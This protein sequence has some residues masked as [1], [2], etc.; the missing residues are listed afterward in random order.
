MA[1]TD[2]LVISIR[3]DL[4]QLNRQLQQ[5]DQRLNNTQQQGQQTGQSLDD[6]FSSASDS[7]KQLAA[8]IGIAT[9]AIVGMSAATSN[10]V[11]EF[12][13][14]ANSLGLSYRQLERLNAVAAA[15]NLETDMM[16]D[17][18]KTLNEQVGEAVNGNKDYEDSFKRLGLSM[19]DL[20][21]MGTDEQ[22]LTVAQALSEV[23]NQADKAQIGGT[24]FGDNWLPALKLTEQ[25]VKALTDQY[26]QFNKKLNDTDVTRLIELDKAF[27]NA[28]A[29]LE[30]TAKSITSQLAPALTVATQ[31]FNELFNVDADN[32][33]QPKITLLT[34]LTINFSAVVV[35]VASVV[36]GA[37]ELIGAAIG[38]VGAVFGGIFGGAFW[39]MFDAVAS[40]I[41]YIVK[42]YQELYN[43]YAKFSNAEPIKVIEPPNGAIFEGYMNI[44]KDVS[45][46]AGAMLESGLSNFVDGLTGKAGQAIKK[47][48]EDAALAVGGASK[49]TTKT[50]AKGGSSVGEEERKKLEELKKASAEYLNTLEE[51]SLNEEQ[52]LNKHRDDALKQL[53]D[54]LKSNAITNE[55]HRQGELS[56]WAVYFQKMGELSQKHYDAELQKLIDQQT[57]EDELLKIKQDAGLKVLEEANLAG[58]TELEILENNHAAKMEAL[59]GLAEVSTGLDQEIKNAELILEQEHQAKKLDILLGTQNKFLAITKTFQKSTLDGALAFFAADFGGFSQHSRKMFELQKAAKTAQ[60]I[61]STPAAVSAAMQ[62][63]W[64]QGAALGGFGA[65]ALAAAYGAAALAQQV[66]QLRAIQSASFGGGSAGGA[67]AGGGG[68]IS[69]P[70]TEQAQQPL[71]QRFVN[72]S[73]SG[74]DNTLYSKDGVRQLI[75]RINEEVK[76][77]ATLRVL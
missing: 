6:S 70:Q 43:V 34:D 16:I 51:A 21:R 72:I 65:P 9:A 5:V 76:D 10:S 38:K 59:R 27:D 66:G 50:T 22:L 73:L 47:E 11:R 44:I 71:T 7:A 36:R 52:L 23:S 37:F 54:Y 55:Q 40:S 4:D 29:G 49:E 58:Q 32:E 8:A 39:A 75:N 15:S 14:L 17:L 57:R 56:I 42:G 18:A 3:A 2:D 30:A 35:N 61:L 41:G 46:T 69:T 64:S 60:I 19:S 24:L 20:S 31:K 28:I 12:N 26:D 74:N 77:G 45:G 13:S 63:G 48:M 53:D 33:L 1:T 67:S 25:N 68:A 62:A